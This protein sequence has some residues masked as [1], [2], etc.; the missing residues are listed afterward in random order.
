LPERNR[1]ILYWQRRVA[2]R[3]WN[4]KAQP[5]TNFQRDFKI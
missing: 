5:L 2:S 3:R 4:W 1:A